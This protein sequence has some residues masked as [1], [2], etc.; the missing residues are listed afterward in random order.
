MNKADTYRAKLQSLDDWV[1][2][3]L[4]ESGLPGPRANLEL[5]QAVADEGDEALF[6]RLL[7]LGHDA[8]S[9]NTPQVFLAVCGIVG[10]GRLLAN[11]QAENL[12]TL[13]P[14]AS[15]PR[16][17]IREGVAMALQ[18]WGDA[19]LNGLLREMRRWSAGNWLE[20]RAAAAA[21]CEPR[22]LRSEKHVANVLRLLDRI[23]AALQ[24]AKNRAGDDFKV[25]RQALGYCWSV[26]VVASPEA[27]KKA[28]E[29]WLTS[30]DPNVA[31]IMRENLKKNRLARMDARWVQTWAVRLA[32]RR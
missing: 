6:K 28:M 8:A 11:G 5:V 17:R 3:L 20:M 24:R 1:P 32:N 19:D 29:K 21:L 10:L 30:D 2:F 15:D 23:T 4:I 31:W 12:A 7:A 9:D 14:F 18:R 27:G 13:R 25:L 26:A 16:W 22:L